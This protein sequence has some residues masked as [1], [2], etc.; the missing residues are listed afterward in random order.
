[1]FDNGTTKGLVSRTLSC[2][3]SACTQDTISSLMILSI[4]ISLLL[5]LALD[6][7]LLDDNGP[8][9]DTCFETLALG[10]SLLLSRSLSVSVHTKHLPLMSL[11]VSDLVLA[12]FEALDKGRLY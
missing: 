11:F 2:K 6:L 1:M 10:L 7:R 4:C 8:S 12:N 9:A 5:V 3:T